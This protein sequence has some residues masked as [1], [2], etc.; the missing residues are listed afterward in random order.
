MPLTFPLA[1]KVT[2]SGPCFKS[3]FNVIF[4]AFVKGSVISTLTLVSVNNTS[5]SIS[6]P[7]ILHLNLR[8]PAFLSNL[9]STK[10]TTCSALECLA[11]N[12]QTSFSCLN[13]TSNSNSLYSN[14]TLKA[15]SLYSTSNSSFFNRGNVDSNSISIS[16]GTIFASIL[17]VLVLNLNKALTDFSFSLLIIFKVV[18]SSS[19]ALRTILKST[20]HS[21]RSWAAFVTKVIL[22]VSLKVTSRF[23][24]RG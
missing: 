14:S 20:L 13:L 11:S 15:V 17:R 12:D 5:N 7:T 16:P 8:V 9:A 21:E 3:P 10:L 23:H 18:V 19:L 24:S 1:F 22:V 2:P 6:L 4:P